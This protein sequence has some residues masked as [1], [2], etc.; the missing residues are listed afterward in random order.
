MNHGTPHTRTVWG[1]VI[2][3]LLLTALAL[4]PPPAG[5]Q[6]PN[7]SAYRD[8]AGTNYIVAF[9]DT[10]ANQH[11]HENV[12]HLFDDYAMIAIY[13]AVPNTITI[14]G[15]SGYV[16]TIEN[17]GNRF[18][19]IDLSSTDFRA[20]RSVIFESGRIVSTTFRIEAAQPVVVY[21]YLMTEFG[22]EAWTPIPVE[23]WGTEYYAAA[24]PG[25][26]VYD[27]T[28]QGWSGITPAPSEILVIAAYNNTLVSIYPN[29]P[30]AKYPQTTVTLNAG[31][32]YQVQ[33]FVDTRDE[34]LG[35]D[36]IDLGG[37][38]IISTRPVGVITGNTRT[39]VVDDQLGILKN[40]MKNMLIEW[41]AP[42]E[43]HG[44]EFVYMPTWDGRQPT[45]NNAA[46]QTRK[47]EFVRMYAT[48]ADQTEG[49]MVAGGTPPI[50]IPIGPVDRGRF[51]EMRFGMPTARFFRTQEP[52][53]MMMHS[54]AISRWLGP[55]PGDF[56]PPDPPPPGGDPPPL[57]EEPPAGSFSGMFDVWGAYMVE[58]IPREQWS[59][60]APFYAPASPAEFEHF[61]NVV[62]DTATAS[63]IYLNDGSRFVFNRGV[64]DGTPYTWGVMGVRA[65]EDYWIEGRDGAKFYGV[66]YG[67]KKGREELLY[68]PPPPIDP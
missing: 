20:P 39:A 57:P 49:V 11:D 30:L 67:L 51:Q 64:I 55:R 33:S 61:V 42:V 12:T 65:A 53:Q 44:R 18:S 34:A 32:A 3:T 54:S 10:T 47:A 9:P 48:G 66:A 36:Q 38:R 24:I 37:S 45:A 31:Q 63:Q 2:A 43:L 46:E 29:G 7:L 6:T 50:D 4:M 56:K 21:C 25:D 35:T 26:Y 19:A 28:G 1:S 52:T 68:I 5:A 27:I 59:S 8:I 41:L 62:T 16:K 17:P 14:R 22:A 58:L 60:F 13:S 23:S 15:S 40:P